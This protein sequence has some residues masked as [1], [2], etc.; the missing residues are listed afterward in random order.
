MAG[1]RKLGEGESSE[2]WEQAT[3]VI[4]D[5]YKAHCTPS[6]I[7]I[8]QGASSEESFKSVSFQG[9]GWVGDIY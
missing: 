1:L 2:I 7:G 9:G 8:V 6:L 4:T 3:E 5:A